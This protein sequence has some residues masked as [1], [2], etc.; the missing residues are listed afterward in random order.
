MKTFGIVMLVVLFLLIGG[1]IF[2]VM[3]K[4]ANLLIRKTFKTLSGLEIVSAKAYEQSKIDNMVLTEMQV[5]ARAKADSLL[6][7]NLKISEELKLKEIRSKNLETRVRALENELLEAKELFD[8]MSVNEQILQFD[9]YT[10]GSK[11]SFISDHKGHEVIITEPSRVADAAWQMHHGKAMQ[12]IAETQ[13]QRIH[14]IV[15][16]NNM[17]ERINT[18]LNNAIDQRNEENRLGVQKLD[19][20]NNAR[21]ETLKQARTI[22]GVGVGSLIVTIA[23]IILL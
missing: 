7:E 12:V 10:I 2:I 19:N 15:D 8:S 5:Q 20:C 13:Q 1:T 18:N 21:K 6:A 3:N 14:E 16:T 9:A 11:P 23:I 22:G 4:P 17:L